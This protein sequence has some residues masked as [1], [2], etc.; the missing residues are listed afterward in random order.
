MVIFPAYISVR[1]VCSAHRGQ[2]RTTDALD[3]QMVASHHVGSSERASSGLTLSSLFSLTAKTSK[4]FV[5]N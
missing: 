2:K 5:V 3:L 1:H 4:I